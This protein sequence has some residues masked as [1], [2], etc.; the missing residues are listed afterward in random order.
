MKFGW[1]MKLRGGQGG[2]VRE[3]I[4]F[5]GDLDEVLAED[6]PPA[7]RH[8]ASILAASL[9]AILLVGGFLKTD[10]VV[11]GSGR[12]AMDRPTIV[13]QP[14]ERSVVKALTVRRG[15]HVRRGQLLALL[16]QT[17]TQAD[18]SAAQTS[19]H[20]I[21][22]RLSRLEAELGGTTFRAS[23]QDQEERVQASLMAERRLQ[24]DSRLASFDEGIKHDE[25]S[26]V[27]SQDDRVS[28]ATQLAIA[29]NIEALRARLLKDEVGSRLQYLDSQTARLQAERQFQA[30]ADRIEELRH[31][32]EEKK[33]ERRGFVDGWRRDILEEIAA[34]HAEQAKVEAAL[35]KA[36]RLQT[37]VRI[38]APEDGTVLDVASR[39]AG[40]VLREAEPLITI[41]PAGA[42]LVAQIDVGS[43]DVGHV[44]Q[45]Q[46]VVVK[47][48]AFPYQQHGTLR[49][50]VRS[51]AGESFTQSDGAVHG[52]IE[53]PAS[54]APFGAF[55]RVDIDLLDQVMPGLG[56][57]E[58]LMPGMTLTAE[59]K[60]GTRT[61]L[62]YFLYPITRGFRESMREP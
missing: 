22:T 46:A 8:V 52:L 12:L 20:A 10:I 5:Q 49:G 13:L 37:M 2:L 9:A 4:P 16:D 61:L 29:R 6:P 39:S 36:S 56:K 25:A 33:A 60:V 23:R 19:A 41:L 44:R 58:G 31:D 21:T 57:E 53:Q 40:S 42:S 38:E 14:L 35:A 26:I 1:P 62:G 24:Y 47:V 7:L 27:S 51:V 3:A 30:A 59:V 11:S 15:D 55:H 17:F 18:L 45:G 28:I 34:Q 43:I 48:D 50:T 32:I 54:R